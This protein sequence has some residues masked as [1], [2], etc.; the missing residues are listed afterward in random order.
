MSGR[1]QLTARSVAIFLFSA[2]V[3]GCSQGAENSTNPANVPE[4]VYSLE[5]KKIED[6][7]VKFEVKRSD[8]VQNLD[9]GTVNIEFSRRDGRL[10]GCAI[11]DAQT[12][13][14]LPATCKMA[15]DTLQIDLGS[16][17]KSYEGLRFELHRSGSMYVGMLQM[18]AMLIP[19][20]KVNFASAEMKPVLN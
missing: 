8:V 12:G 7:G 11:T 20:G 4:G 16:E 5:W 17:Q 9:T 6:S 1:K 13:V 14:V 10:I 3:S 15:K 19:G 18:R 2:L